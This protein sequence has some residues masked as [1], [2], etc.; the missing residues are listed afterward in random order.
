L[1]QRESEADLKIKR[2]KKEL[3]SDWMSLLGQHE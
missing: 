3:P 1:Q 2:R